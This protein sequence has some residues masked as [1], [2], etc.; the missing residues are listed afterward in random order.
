MSEGAG[1]IYCSVRATRQSA[2]AS[3]DNRLYAAAGP[4]RGDDSPDATVRVYQRITKGWGIYSSRQEDFLG[5]ITAYDVRPLHLRCPTTRFVRA[6]LLPSG[7]NGSMKRTSSTVIMTS[8]TATITLANHSRHLSTSRFRTVSNGHA[9][10]MV[11]R[12]DLSASVLLQDHDRWAHRK[13]RA[14][15]G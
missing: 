1:I 12:A 8:S 15:S 9:L 14:A 10:T 7:S 6:R 11:E 3:G 5:P 4:P 13:H 2:R